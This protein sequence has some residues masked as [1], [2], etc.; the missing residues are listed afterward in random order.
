MSDPYLKSMTDSELAAKMNRLGYI[1]QDLRK[2]HEKALESLQ[3]CQWEWCDRHNP[4]R[5]E[6]S[7][8]SDVRE[9]DRNGG[10]R[11]EIR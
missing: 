9:I 4:S 5:F 8:M 11:K 10:A 6:Q 1:L 7:Y 3:Q 2:E